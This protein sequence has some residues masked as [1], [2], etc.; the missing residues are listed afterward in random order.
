M[1]QVD[2]S[3]HEVGELLPTGS[4]LL[5]GSAEASCP[6]GKA[7]IF[8]ETQKGLCEM[9]LLHLR[10]HLLEVDSY[11]QELQV[12]PPP[13]LIP[14]DWQDRTRNARANHCC[15]C[16]SAAVMHGTAAQG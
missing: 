5:D 4:L 7:L 1:P 13:G 8:G 16:A 11:S 12:L 15:N 9:I 14:S 2:A 3:F 6:C 10:D